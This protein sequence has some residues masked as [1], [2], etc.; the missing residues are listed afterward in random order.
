MLGPV[1]WTIWFLATLLEGSVVVCSIHRKAFKRYFFLNLYM[2][3]SVLVSVVRFQVLM[4]H[5]TSSNEYRYTYFYSD[6]LL[7]ITLFFAVISLYSRIFQELR[8]EGY[9]RMGAVLTL[10]GT[11]WF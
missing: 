7:T 6:A 3:L 2:L 10:A 5:P 8:V 11:A 1:D 4:S 9:L